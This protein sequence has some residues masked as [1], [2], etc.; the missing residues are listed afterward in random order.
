[1]RL[2]DRECAAVL[3]LRRERRV[4]RAIELA[5]GI[6]GD[7]QQLGVGTGGKRNGEN[8]ED[9]QEGDDDV[10]NQRRRAAQ[11][12]DAEAG[13]RGRSLSRK[14]TDKDPSAGTE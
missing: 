11:D 6:V 8:G 5:R 4:Q 9:R 3:V 14:G 13:R 12:L 2:A 7:V 10:P 1:M